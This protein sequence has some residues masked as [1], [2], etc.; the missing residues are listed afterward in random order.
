MNDDLDRDDDN[1]PVLEWHWEGDEEKGEVPRIVVD[2]KGW[3][4]PDEAVSD[5]IANLAL[6]RGRLDI[7][8]RYI[9]ETVIPPIRNRKFGPHATDTLWKLADM[10]E[11]QPGLRQHLRLER[12]ERGSPS[13]PARTLYQSLEIGAQIDRLVKGGDAVAAAVAIVCDARAIGKTKAYE[14]YENFKQ[15]K[16]CDDRLEP[17]PIPASLPRKKGI[18][19][20]VGAKQKSQISVAP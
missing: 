10:L 20:R 13:D 12:A 11:A 17:M 14:A 15:Y 8:A 1:A 16:K 5:H 19:R 7:V 2:R 18:A 4:S 9:R 6:E 3:P